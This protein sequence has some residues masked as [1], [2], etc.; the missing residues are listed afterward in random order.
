MIPSL[1]RDMIDPSQFDSMI[2]WAF[3]IATLIYTIIGVTGYLMFGNSV[4][5]EVSC[6]SFVSCT[7]HDRLI[8]LFFFQ[9]SKDLMSTPGYNLT[10]NQ[11]A[12]WG[13]VIAPLSKFALATRPV[14]R[15]KCI[16]CRSG[17]MADDA[18]TAE[19]HTRDYVGHRSRLTIH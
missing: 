7:S 14:S 15:G 17:S 4:S 11:V 9:F 16:H 18:L 13:L 3:A 8:S 2:E 1:A 12:L 19:Y 6:P 5:D 10:L